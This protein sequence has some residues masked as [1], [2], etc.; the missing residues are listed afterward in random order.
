MMIGFPVEPSDDENFLFSNQKPVSR[1]L[2]IAS[3]VPREV[4]RNRRVLTIATV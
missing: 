3:R 4:Q 2:L 1:L